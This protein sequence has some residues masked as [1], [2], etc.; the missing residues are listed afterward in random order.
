MN[1]YQKG[2]LAFVAVI[3]IAV[4]LVAALIARQTT[5]EFRHYTVLYSNR[6]QMIADA[7]AEYYQR[8]GSWAGLDAAL[9]TLTPGRG[10]GSGAMNSAGSEGPDWTYRVADAAGRV[11]A[12]ADGPAVGA[13]S[14]AEIE[15][16]LPITVEGE[17]VGYLLPDNQASHSVVLDAPAEFFLD[18]VRS[19][20]VLG[21]LA[22]F[23]AAM[24]LAAVL[25]RSI[26]APL[27]T[28]TAAT[29]RIAEGDLDAHA[30]V[31]GSDEIAQLAE[32]FNAMAES[33]R[34]AE[35][36]RRAQTSDIAHELR[37]PMAALQGTL[38]ALADG[39][40]APTQ[41]NIQ[42]ALDQVQTL[43]RLVDD[44]RVLAQADAGALRLERHPVRLDE[45]LARAATAHQKVMAE[46]GITLDLQ[47][48]PTPPVRVDYERIM[49]VANNILSNAA[50]YVSGGGEVR[51]EVHLT[52]DVDP[53]DAGVTARIADNGP[54]ISAAEYE[55][56]FE[57]FWRGDASRSRATGGS[58]LGLAIARR[59]IELHGGRIW[60]EPTPG[61]GLTIAFWLP[62]GVR[63]FN[64]PQD[65][66]RKK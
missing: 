19:A 35:A 65:N 46:K 40:Y 21:G 54:G 43:N 1:L 50:R 23:L 66:E 48:P 11:V 42:P 60:A 47:L 18:Q 25:T 59:I 29:E 16:A 36:A 45:L 6:T 61:G 3:L 53:D 9:P 56:L 34:R 32:T 13:L 49:Q 7:L 10:R 8:H 51:G 62:V 24:V 33:L 52:L 38:E 22:A 2:L 5:T 57:R 12:D 37:N 27:R 64:S 39:I 58:G 30:P 55:H 4:V 28:L 20:A 41:E 26:V 17:R 15:R 31:R 44:L 63:E 14:Q